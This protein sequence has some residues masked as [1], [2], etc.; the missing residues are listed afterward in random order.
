MA[1][2]GW[3]ASLGVIALTTLVSLAA[4]AW[5]APPP[6]ARAV[7]YVGPRRLPLRSALAWRLAAGLG[8]LGMCFWG[9][10]SWV[11]DAFLE[12]GW[13]EGEAAAL[14]AMVNVGALL[15][16]LSV[17]VLHERLGS[18]RTHLLGSAALFL[19]GA[20]L[21]VVAPSGGFAWTF[22]FG[23]GN[24]LLFPALLTIPLDVSRDARET[25][26]VT[27]MMMGVGYVL[28][29]IAPFVFGVVRDL[30][31]SFVAVLWLAAAMAAALV[32]VVAGLGPRR[33]AQGIDGASQ[34]S[35]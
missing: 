17:F 31:G 23:Y 15:G 21:L 4:W 16:N 20:V 12:H 19:A 25:A 30:S 18:R 1:L 2:G 10:T 5:F 27:A 3:R 13:S 6:A 22:L 14:T 34:A 28:S 26:A 29:G 7:E 35:A 8:L 33:L 11:T 32:L 24:G 9:V